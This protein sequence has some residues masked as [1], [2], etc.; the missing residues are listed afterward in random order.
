MLQLNKLKLNLQNKQKEEKPVIATA[1]NASD[2]MAKMKARLAAQEAEKKAKQAAIITNKP[3]IIY[4]SPQLMTQGI[5]YTD[6]QKEFI[7][8]G[9]AG[10][11]LVLFGAAGTGKTTSLKGLT[12]LILEKGELPELIDAKHKYLLPGT[13]GIVITSYMNRAVFNDKK[14]L[15]DL[16]HN[17]LTIHKL[18]EYTR[19]WEEI[20]DSEGKVRNKMTFQPKR[21]K[22][23]KLDSQIR[24]IVI[25]EAG[26]TP[27]DLY[28]LL[29]EALPEPE[30]VQ[31]I[32]MGDLSQVPPVFGGAVLG[33][34]GAELKENR[35]I[36]TEVKRQAKDSPILDLATDI[37][38]GNE[39]PAKHFAD[40]NNEFLQIKPWKRTVN[41]DT[42]ILG[43]AEFMKTHYN[44]GTYNPAND[45]IIMLQNV[46]FGIDEMNRHIAQF[47]ANKDSREVYEII[48][49]FNKYYFSAG[50]IVFYA[51]EDFII[52]E[53]IYNLD[54]EGLMPQKS[55][56]TLNYWGHNTGITT[57]QEMTDA[58][59]NAHLD[60]P[61]TDSAIEERKRKASHT[62]IIQNRLDPEREI[63]L[64]TASEI[65]N[66]RLGY[67]CTVHRALGSEWEKVFFLI[68]HTNKSML[69]RELLYTGITRAQKYLTI[70]CEPDTF[71]KGVRN[72]KIPGESIDEKLIYFQNKTAHIP[73]FKKYRLTR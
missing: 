25:D 9:V 13:P 52:K 73:R 54:Y 11:S 67:A 10:E 51:K 28:Q 23:Y 56:K 39:I 38:L 60:Q 12:R 31:F 33:Y 37:R 50:D 24:V 35:V 30:K 5:Q 17:C 14:V 43:M 34:K 63:H 3:A 15:P 4:D 27:L 6:A 70:V 40:R 62:V 53:I 49:G 65:N 48:A 8:R 72:Q 68:H 55:A 21:N 22:G 58:E 1:I 18:L 41:E 16:A 42:A 36:L 64:D 59:I 20:I 32:F 69:Y 44:T 26:N 47:L 45:I 71:V 19:V 2:L 46:K 7:L 66:L 57:M 29:I 61:F